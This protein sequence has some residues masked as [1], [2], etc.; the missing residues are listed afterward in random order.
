MA[1]T[2]YSVEVTRGDTVRAV[3]PGLY[4]VYGHYTL[5]GTSIVVND[6]VEM[7]SVPLGARVVD[8]ILDIGDCDTGTSCGLV[9]GDGGTTNRY[10][11]ATTLGVTGGIAHANAVGYDRTAYTVNDTID[12]K[13]ITAPE[14]GLTTS[15]MSLVAILAIDN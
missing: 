12:I 7:V 15:V 10:I 1:S 9:V 13:F 6:V 5:A 14:T 3:T 8:V 11:T 2:F 4:S